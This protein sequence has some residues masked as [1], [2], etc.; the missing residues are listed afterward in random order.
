MRKHVYRNCGKTCGQKCQEKETE[1]KLKYELTYRDTTNL[2]YQMYDHTG[3]SRGH[4]S[5]KKNYRKCVSQSK[6]AVSSFTQKTASLGTLHIIRKVL[7]SETG[8]LNGGNWCWFGRRSAR[9]KRR[10]TMN[11][12]VTI[13]TTIIIIGLL[14]AAVI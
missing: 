9:G 14:V 5:S 3:N 8:S 1:N 12:T 10:V 11:D 7:Q 6:Q 13:T 4:R 2:V